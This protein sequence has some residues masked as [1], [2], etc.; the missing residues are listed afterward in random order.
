M[1]PQEHY[2]R[3]ELREAVAAATEQVRQH[4]SDPAPRIFLCELLSFTG[5]L[6]RADRQ[7]DALGHQDPQQMVG[8]QVFRRLVRAEQARQQ[9]YSDGRVPEFLG[10]PSPVLR[11]HL[12]ASIRVR[13]GKLDEAADLLARAE[14]ERPRVSG[15]CN[16]QPF[17]DLRDLDDLT[18]PFLEVLTS[19]GQYFWVPWDRIESAEFEAPTRPLDLVWRRTHLVVR[20]GPD[21][22]VFVPTLYSGTHN[23]PDDAL[24]LGRSTDWRGG[25][26]APVRGFG[27]RMLLTGEATV[28]ILEVQSLAV[29]QP[30]DADRPADAETPAP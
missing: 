30:A 10:V 2:E 5:D 6:E 8:V 11:L 27:Q 28:P 22:V 3:G 12:E 23:D 15:T 19:A 24:R 14:A 4:P 17:D 7:L 18:A 13:E 20:D 9:F 16:G 26:G 1:R 25:D 29:D 21:G